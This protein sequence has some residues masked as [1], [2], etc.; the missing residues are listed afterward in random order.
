MTKTE[1]AERR[2]RA[3]ELWQQGVGGAE[4]AHQLGMSEMGLY[5]LIKRM[6]QAGE[7]L[8]NRK[9]YLSKRFE[10]IRELEHPEQLQFDHA[11]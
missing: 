11:A 2:A 6:R 4:I 10:R 9:P 3:A 8:T 7:P 5:M 1:Q